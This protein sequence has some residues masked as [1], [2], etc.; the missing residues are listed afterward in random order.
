MNMVFWEGNGGN[1]LNNDAEHNRDRFRT[2]KRLT[3]TVWLGPCGP[4]YKYVYLFVT[5]LHESSHSDL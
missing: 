2:N 1:I 4:S 5:L 3:F